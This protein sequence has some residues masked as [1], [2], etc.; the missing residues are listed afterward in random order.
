VIGRGAS[1]APWPQP[2]VQI[3]LPGLGGLY[4]FRAVIDGD[5]LELLVQRELL[6]QRLAQLGVVVHD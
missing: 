6:D 4:P 3:D 5:R 2:G 1:P